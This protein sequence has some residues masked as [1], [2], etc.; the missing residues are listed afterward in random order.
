M[1]GRRCRITS[2]EPARDCRFS[3]PRDEPLIIV[4]WAKWGG[5][6][7]VHRRD[8]DLADRVGRIIDKHQLGNDE[9]TSPTARLARTS[10]T[11]VADVL[12][13]N[14]RSDHQAGG[15]TRRT[16]VHLGQP[17]DPAR[18]APQ[19][20]RHQV[21]PC[22]RCSQRHDDHRW[23][24]DARRHL[25]STSWIRHGQRGIWCSHVGVHGQVLTAPL[26][27]TADS[28][29]IGKN[30]RARTVDIVVRWNKNQAGHRQCWQVA[31]VGKCRATWNP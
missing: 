30:N 13:A 26:A 18:R 29:I 19:Y 20:R 15:S 23:R 25:V 3:S 14:D 22:I 2:P 7:N 1:L 10:R 24:H 31:A 21:A 27:P 28:L 17:R 6:T 11:R 8:T 5:S 9:Q 16:P 12:G 4:A